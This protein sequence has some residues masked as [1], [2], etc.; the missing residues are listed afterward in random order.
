[1]LSTEYL[2]GRLSPP[3]D[4]SPVAQGVICVNSPAWF[5]YFRCLPHICGAH[6]TASGIGP[7]SSEEENSLAPTFP[8]PLPHPK[9]ISSINRLVDL[10][11]AGSPVFKGQQP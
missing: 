4:A 5:L 1:M 8:H 6:D 7:P 3:I 10:H 2:N 11:L 9:P